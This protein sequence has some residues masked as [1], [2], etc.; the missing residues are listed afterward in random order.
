MFEVQI[1]WLFLDVK[2]KG[3]LFKGRPWSCHSEGFE[4]WHSWENEDLRQKKHIMSFGSISSVFGL[5]DTSER[6]KS[7]SSVYGWLRPQR[8]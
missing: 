2:S 7:I 8:E 5:V 1:Y 6:M 4:E 3:Y